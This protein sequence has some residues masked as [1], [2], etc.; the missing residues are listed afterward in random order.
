MISA[1][2]GNHFFIP[3]GVDH[4]R[5]SYGRLLLL[6]QLLPGSVGLLNIDRRFGLKLSTA[7]SVPIQIE[8][9]VDDLKHL[10]IYTGSLAGRRQTPCSVST[11]LRRIAY[12]VGGK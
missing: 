8:F 10:R 11:V 3:C 6:D 7:I 9:A 1:G 2:R 12:R 4:S 5:P